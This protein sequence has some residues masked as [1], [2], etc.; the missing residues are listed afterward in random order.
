[1]SG[2]TKLMDWLTPARLE[3]IIGDS[4][5]VDGRAKGALGLIDA[6]AF[7]RGTTGSNAAMARIWEGAG[8]ADPSIYNQGGDFPYLQVPFL[9]VMPRIKG[10]EGRHRTA[11]ALQLMEVDPGEA[12]ILPYYIRNQYGEG[13]DPAK[14]PKFMRV[15]GEDF[16]TGG[17][18]DPL[19]ITE[20]LPVTYDNEKALKNYLWNVPVKGEYKKGGLV[21][22]SR[23]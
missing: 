22:L 11:K 5:Y 1:M 17:T 7:L 6:G 8:R 12:L 2:L 10:H 21:C 13:L 16:G 20:M 3:R 18:G 19:S 9:D 14:I 15:A 23:Q 4:A